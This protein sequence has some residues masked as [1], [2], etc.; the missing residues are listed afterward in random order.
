[1]T[2][3]TGVPPKSRAKWPL[4]LAAV[5]AVVIVAVA[6]AVVLAPRPRPSPYFA[7]NLV[8]GPAARSPSQ[9][10]AVIDYPESYSE[11]GTGWFNVTFRSDAPVA[12]CASAFGVSES[13]ADCQAGA[14]S[15]ATASGESGVISTGAWGETGI[16]AESTS[17]AATTVHF[18]WWDNGTALFN[19]TIGTQARGSGSI[20]IPAGAYAPS[21]GCM[22]VT[23]PSNGT[24]GGTLFSNATAPV[25]IGGELSF[26]GLCPSVP[27]IPSFGLSNVTAGVSPFGVVA[28]LGLNVLTVEVA[29]LNP[30]SVTVSLTVTLAQTHQVS[31]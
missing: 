25:D 24:V 22:A 5:V 20:A 15:N 16:I 10:M 11:Y 2:E 1:M 4:I 17:G 3:S 29:S 6:S 23:L 30:I 19:S 18:D 8:V 7:T 27:F 13:L 9:G 26:V 31:V 12:V 14:T 21:Y 28:G